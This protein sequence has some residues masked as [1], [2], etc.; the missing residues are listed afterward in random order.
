M[1][2]T[3][4]NIS[5]GSKFKLSYEYVDSAHSRTALFFYQEE[6]GKRYHGSLLGCGRAALGTI[7]IYR[8][9]GEATGDTV[10]FY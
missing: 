9:G 5:Y 10:A 2:K 3:E 8:K 6:V 1:F 4:Q 7:G